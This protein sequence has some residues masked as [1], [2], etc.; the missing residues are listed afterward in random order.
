MFF[1][2]HRTTRPTGEVLAR[3]LGLLH[4]SHPP[5]GRQHVLIRWGNRERVDYRP[6][7]TINPAYAIERATDKLASL[8]RMRE[9]GVVVPNFSRDPRS[10]R[11]P[12]LSRSINHT[13]GQDIGLC[14]Q[15]GD[16]SQYPT[17]DFFV[18][19]IPTAREYRARVVG[20]ECV[21]VSEKVHTGDTYT[22]WIRNYEHGHTFVSPHTRLNGF[23]ESLAVAAVKA[24]GLDFGAVDLV[25]GDDGHTYILEVNT[26]PALA[27]RSAAAMLGGLTRL[28]AERAGV[29]LEPQY[30]V[31]NELSAS[32]DGDTEDDTDSL[33]GI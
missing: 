17:A 23:Q 28:I 14:M 20:N 29:E 33:E 26:A 16:A 4:G 5:A 3:A 24:H 7:I 21:R 19:Y 18:E 27:P 10:L 25:V 13:R 32:D 9:R 2:Y 8:E 15:L 22:P 11:A 30:D 12:Y 31:L 1:L 6:T